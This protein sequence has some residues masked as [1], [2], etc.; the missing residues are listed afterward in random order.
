MEGKFISYLR[1]STQ[2]QGRSGLGLEAQR[3]AVA[4]YLNGGSWELLAEYVEVES[5]KKDDRPQLQKALHHCKVTGASLVIAKLDRLSRNARFLLELQEAGTSFVAADMPDANEFTVGIMAM[6]AQQERKMISKRTKEALA[7]AKARGVKL[8]N[9]KGAEHLRGLGN[10]AAVDTIKEKAQER[11]V[12]LMPILQ[13]ILDGGVTSYRGIAQE[14]NKR[15]IRTA[16]GGQWHPASVS[17]IMKRLGM[18]S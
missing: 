13:D 7:A 5:G 14:L 1:V 8:G 12:D 10:E 4:D 17:R 2:R 18:D 11:A 16:R 3:K 6:L 9:P 15:S